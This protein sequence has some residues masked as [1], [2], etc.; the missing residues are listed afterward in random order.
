MRSL[1][2]ISG[3]SSVTLTLLVSS[4][5]TS[6]SRSLG[7]LSG[8]GL[9]SSHGQDSL[10]DVQLCSQVLETFIGQRVVVPLPRELGLDV[11]L[12]GQGLH[13]LDDPQVLDINLLVLGL[14]EVLLG[15][16][17]TLLEEVLVDLLSVFLGN[18]HAG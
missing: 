9:Q 18:K 16:S 14:V 3:S 4:G 10:G 2:L 13:G 7:S 6:E 15:N 1:N 17:N 8:S 12:G 5:A 11:T